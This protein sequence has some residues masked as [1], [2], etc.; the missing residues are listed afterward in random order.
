MDAV[1]K[2]RELR[3]QL[4]IMDV[5]MPRMDGIQATRLIR[6]EIPSPRSS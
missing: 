6:E 2:A 3:P 4:I 5:S 1:T